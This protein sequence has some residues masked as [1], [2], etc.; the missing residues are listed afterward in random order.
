LEKLGT[1]LKFSI[2]YH[3][4]MNS[5]N[6]VENIAL[7][8]MPRVSMRVNHKSRDEYLSRI[9]SEYNRVVHK[10][11]NISPFEDVYVRMY[12]LKREGG[13]LFKGGFRKL[14]KLE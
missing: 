10:N 1:K 5:Q 13:E 3:P 7:Y 11:T 8:T 14:F 4:Q 9:E 6:E 12:G 2:S